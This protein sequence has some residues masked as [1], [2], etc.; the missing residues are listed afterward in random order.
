MAKP[1]AARLAGAGTLAFGD[2]ADSVALGAVAAEM[3]GKEMAKLSRGVKLKAMALMEKDAEMDA[4][5]S[6]ASGL[7]LQQDRGRREAVRQLYRKLDKTE[8]WV[9]NNYYKLPIERQV[10]TLVTVNGF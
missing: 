1:R 6:L 10:A 9:E 8:E 7:Q 4:L 2:M 5:T 3:E